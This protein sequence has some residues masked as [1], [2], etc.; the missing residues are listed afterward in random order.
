M[1]LF[2]LAAFFAFLYRRAQLHLH[3]KIGPEFGDPFSFQNLQH[4][5]ERCFN[6]FRLL[7]QKGLLLEGNIR[8]SSLSAE[9]IQS[10]L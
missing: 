1:S 7:D 10:V 6:S 2:V 9:S 4:C 5:I 8:G 3:S